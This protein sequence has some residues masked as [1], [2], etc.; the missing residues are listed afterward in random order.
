[1]KVFYLKNLELYGI[2]PGPQYIR[3]NVWRF[4]KS[5]IVQFIYE[6]MMNLQIAYWLQSWKKFLW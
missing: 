5:M 4:Y 6:T 3:T 2:R 1:M